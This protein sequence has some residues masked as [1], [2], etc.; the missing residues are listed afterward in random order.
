MKRVWAVD[1]PPTPRDALARYG[2][3]W[4]ADSSTHTA[5]SELVASLRIA[6][7][8]IDALKAELL[9]KEQQLAEARAFISTIIDAPKDY[10]AEEGM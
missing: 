5:L 3:A 4:S 7:D 1:D 10:P 9:Q 2:G 8:E 6:V